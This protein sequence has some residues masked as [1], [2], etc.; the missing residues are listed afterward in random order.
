MKVRILSDLHLEHT[1]Y[2]REFVDGLDSG[3]DL[4]ILAGDIDS[5]LD[6]DRTLD[7]FCERFSEVIYVPGNHVYY[8]SS[9]DKVH[10]ILSAASDKN[11]NLHYLHPENPTVEIDGRTFHGSTGWFRDDPLNIHYERNLGDFNHISGFKPWVYDQQEAFQRHLEENLDEGDIV[12]THH[13][14]SEF[15]V[16]RE[17]KNSMLNRFFVC[18][19]TDLILDRKPAFW[20]FG[21]THTGFDDVLGVTRLICNPRGYPNEP[22]AQMFNTHLDVDLS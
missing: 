18:D 10:D 8:M 2:R 20:F 21:H 9:P 13:L 16:A 6:I 22:S 1:G 17:W 14:P 11:N 3:C 4:L 19:H 5:C 12:I 7:I 15:C